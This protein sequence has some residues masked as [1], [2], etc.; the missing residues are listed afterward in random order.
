[1]IVIPDFGT[2][3]KPLGSDEKPQHTVGLAS[4][5][6]WWNCDFEALSETEEEI[7][8][9]A[10]EHAATAHDMKEIPEE[11]LAKVRAAICDE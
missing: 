2:K 3:W 11:V 4:A 9:K 8:K 7:L 10:A 1:M 5:S 6:W